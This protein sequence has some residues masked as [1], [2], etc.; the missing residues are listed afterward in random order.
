MKRSYVPTQLKEA[1][2]VRKIIFLSGTGTA[3]CQVQLGLNAGFRVF[4]GAFYA[5]A[6]AAQPRHPASRREKTLNPKPYTYHSLGRDPKV[7]ARCVASRATASH[8]RPSHQASRREKPARP[9]RQVTPEK[10]FLLQVDRY[11]DYS[12]L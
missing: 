5:A 8:A 12:T 3:F 10:H 6:Y 2:Y 7:R 9:R 11:M 4:A 1:T